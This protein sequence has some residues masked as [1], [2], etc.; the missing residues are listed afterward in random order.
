V[1]F[2][3]LS[4]LDGRGR[5][6]SETAC[7][8]CAHI[9][10]RERE[11]GIHICVGARFFACTCTAT[12]VHLRPRKRSDTH[13]LCGGVRYRTETILCMPVKDHVG[14]MIA[15][16]EAINKRTGTFGQ[17]DEVRPIG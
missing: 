1:E 5:S 11:I 13:T 6:R 9:M 4:R 14:E 7:P 12:Y 10:E 3:R 8:I 15:V 16:L 2:I 17:Q